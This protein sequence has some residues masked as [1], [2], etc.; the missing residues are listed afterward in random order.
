MKNRPRFSQ[1]GAPE[2]VAPYG[3]G[4]VWY[5]DVAWTNRLAA[6]VIV[7]QA[8]RGFVGDDAHGVPFDVKFGTTSDPAGAPYEHAESKG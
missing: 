4:R 8:L 2:G 5:V 3:H 1:G 6:C 7:L